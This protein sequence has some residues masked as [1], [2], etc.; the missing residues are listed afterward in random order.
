MVIKNSKMIKAWSMELDY[1][2]LNPTALNYE[3]SKL[4]N[5]VNIPQPQH[6]HLENGQLR[7]CIYLRY[8]IKYMT[9]I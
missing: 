8:R 9:N 5:A 2:S 4:N 3:P 6:S 7:V 1:M